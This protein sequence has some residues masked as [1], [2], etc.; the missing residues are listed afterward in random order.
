MGQVRYQR[1]GAAAD[2][3]AGRRVPLP[4]DQR[5]TISDSRTRHRPSVGVGADFTKLASG[6]LELAHELDQRID[7]GFGERVVD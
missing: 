2:A 7:P 3:V 4:R 6:A 1:N 5:A